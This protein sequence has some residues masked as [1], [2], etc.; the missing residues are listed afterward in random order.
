MIGWDD[1]ESLVGVQFVT[2]LLGTVQNPAANPNSHLTVATANLN[3]NACYSNPPAAAGTVVGIDAY[4][5][6]DGTLESDKSVVSSLVTSG[7]AL[8]N[9]TMDHLENYEPAPGWAGIPAA[10]HDTVNNGWLPC[11]SGPEASVCSG[12]GC[13]LDEAT[14]QALLPVNQTVLT[15]NYGQTT[16]QGFRAPRLE[17]NDNGLN[18]LKAIDYQYDSSLEET[19]PAGWVSAAVDA[20]T[21]GQQ[22]FN[23]FPWPYTLDNGSPG[24]WNQQSGGS[25]QWITNFP[26]GLWETPDVRG[27]RPERREP[28]RRDRQSHARREQRRALPVRDACRPSSKTAS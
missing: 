22:G 6:G 7:W 13:C 23:W 19:Q 17:M 26:T 2:S 12:P 5:C 20:N 11:P 15:T 14:W 3:A 28:R 8:A 24:I 21:A 27:V 4:A 1:V 16:I 10:L 9:H 18:A 25:Q